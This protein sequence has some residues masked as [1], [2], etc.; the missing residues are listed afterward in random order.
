MPQLRRDFFRVLEAG[1]VGLFF[2][3]AIRYGFAVLYAHASSADLVQRVPDRGALIGV[4]GIVEPATL[5]REIMIVAALLLLPLFAVVIRR[6]RLSLPLAVILVAL[7]RS[8]ALQIPD[9]EI[10]GSALV[11]GGGLLYLALTVIWRPSFFVPTLLLGLAGD[12]IIR[13][14]DHTYDRTWQGD[15]TVTIARRVDLDMGLIIAVASIALILLAL[16]VW[17]LERREAR[18]QQQSEGY[19]PPLQGWLNMWGALALGAAL[20]LELALLGLPNAVAH[21][22][23]ADYA[24]IVPWLLGA[25]TL[26]LVPEVRDMARRFAGMFDGAWRGWLWALLLG[27]L[28]VVGRRYDGI[29]AAL[30]LVFAQ[31]M[32][33]LSLWWPVQTGLPRRNLT[34]FTILFSAVAFGVLALGDYFTYDYAYVRDL[35]EPYER[36]SDLLRSFRNM[37]L[38][39]AL[40][41]A[42]VLS[43]PM[44]LARRRIPWRG[45]RPVATLSALALVVAISFAGA[46]LASPEVVRRPLNVDCLRAATFNLHGGYSQFFDPNLERAAQLIELNGVDIVLLQEVDTGRLASFGVDQAMWLARRLNMEWAFFPQNE[47]LQ[48][49]AVLSRVPI[50]DTEGLLLPSEGNQAG[51]MHATLAPE[52]LT[53]D[54]MAGDIGDLHVYNAWLGFRIAERDGRPVPEGEQDQNRQMQALLNWVAAR[55][56]PDW[57]DRVI[58]GGTFNYG[59]DSP[60]YGVLRMGEMENPAIK[61]PFAGLRAED[62]LTVFLVDGTAARYDYLWTF[63]LPLTGAMVDQSP[64]AANTSD[65]RSAIV[66]IARR[67]GIMCPP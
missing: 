52:R 41:A 40:I 18:E 29:L 60:L 1:T 20:Y 66:A 63:N 25:T 31:F 26:P 37:G 8:M 22:A 14:L 32:V 7:G 21:W 43:I 3:Q 34:G 46:S 11:V 61:D 59:P 62:A 54:P 57:T 6:W 51:V 50:E 45:G 13:V 36:V 15:Y 16:L 24:G 19:S 55:H 42:F 35:S 49:L 58:L 9:F 28:L 27:L 53:A 56:G 47:E 30:C 65:H 23:G 64:E 2:I 33:G 12:Q 48:G 5:E 4:P 39:L 10:P 67:E 44:I 38:G 17:H